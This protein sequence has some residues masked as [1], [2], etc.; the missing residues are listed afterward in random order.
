M[1]LE[2]DRLHKLLVALRVPKWTVKNVHWASFPA[3]V[4][5]RAAAVAYRLKHKVPRL[6][7]ENRLH[8]PARPPWTSKRVPRQQWVLVKWCSYCY[9]I[10]TS[11]TVKYLPWFV[12]WLVMLAGQA[13]SWQGCKPMHDILLYSGVWN[14]LGSKSTANLADCCGGNSS[15][16][17]VLTHTFCCPFLHVVRSPCSSGDPVLQHCK[18]PVTGGFQVLKYWKE[19]ICLVNTKTSRGFYLKLVISTSE[20]HFC[21]CSCGPS[22]SFY[23]LKLIIH[24]HLYL[25]ISARYLWLQIAFKY[26]PSS[27]P[28][29][30]WNYYL[31]DYCVVKFQLRYGGKTHCS[32]LN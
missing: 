18:N 32:N 25:V 5:V 9:I 24:Q 29:S 7:W 30:M 1:N 31:S 28:S 12:T 11:R 8:L 2:D 17:P 6:S 22:L 20:R 23:G 19:L 26:I 14:A 16:S 15:L 27:S 10:I 4:Q 13:G 3:G 21:L